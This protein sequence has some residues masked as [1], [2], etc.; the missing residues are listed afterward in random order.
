MLDG[1]AICIECDE[2]K[3]KWCADAITRW[4]MKVSQ[5]SSMPY[6]PYDL[7]FI[8]FLFVLLYIMITMQH[9][10]YLTDERYSLGNLLTVLNGLFPFFRYSVSFY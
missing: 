3:K 8:H 2:D 9:T 10:L 5:Q 6:M 7:W 1:C 4:F